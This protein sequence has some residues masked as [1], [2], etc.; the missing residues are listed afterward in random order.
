MKPASIAVIVAVSILL[1]AMSPIGLSSE[2][3]VR[4]ENELS[5][6]FSNADLT[7]HDPIEIVSNTDFETQ[8]W[9]GNGSANNPYRI[10]NLHIT[11]TTH[12]IKIENT[13]VEF[14]ITNCLL[15]GIGDSGVFLSNVSMGNI[16]NCIITEKGFAI[17]VHNSQNCTFA[18]IS[19]E[20]CGF[21]INIDTNS[22][23]CL[24]AHNTMSVDWNGVSVDDSHNISIMNNTISGGHQFG[25]LLDNSDDCHIWNN[26]ISDFQWAGARI[27]RTQN[28]LFE[29]NTVITTTVPYRHEYKYGIEAENNSGLTIHNNTLTGVADTSL[30]LSRY[31]G[32]RIENNTFDNGVCI[33]SSDI[34][35]LDHDVVNNVVQGKPLFY[36]EG[37][38]NSILNAS[39]YGQV[40]IVDAVNVTI[41]GGQF[42]DVSSPVTISRSDNCSIEY[43][44][45]SGCDVYSILIQFC[46][47]V[48]L[49]DL[50][51][52]DANG[53][54][55]FL[56]NSKHS[57]V[58]NCTILDI[59]SEGNVKSG[60]FLEEYC[61]HSLVSGNN[62]HRIESIGIR[63][64]SSEVTIQD[65]NVTESLYLFRGNC[66]VTN[67]NF[68]DGVLFWY[69]HDVSRLYHNF[70]SNFMG[71]KEI[72]YYRDANDT[73]ID[74]ANL[75]QL[76]LI[77]CS[78]MVVNNMITED[79]AQGMIIF[80]CSDVTVE[81]VNMSSMQYG[82]ETTFCDNVSFQEL[83]ISN[84]AIHGL[85]LDSSHN[86]TISNCEFIDNRVGIYADS[87]HNSTISHNL[88]LHNN[89]GIRLS[90][91]SNN[92]IF[93]ND[94][95]YSE[96]QNAVDDAG[97]NTWDN[98]IDTGNA[99]SDYSGTGTYLI[100]GSSGSVDRYPTL[101]ESPPMTTTTTPSPPTSPTSNGEPDNLDGMVYI[102]LAGVGAGILVI[103]VIFLK[104]RS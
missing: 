89:Y 84:S 2:T 77:E 72:G 88:F 95:G 47:N 15:E 101:L 54:G 71:T 17:A 58:I 83:S 11:A 64:Y 91:C 103:V 90:I 8:G 96:Y 36:N 56:D 51:I 92:T 16:E 45:T 23:N 59:H 10:E 73:E 46:T 66:N 13:S 9:P 31:S 57:K 94:I 26:T 69:G 25:I 79:V 37:M 28:C 104:R 27:M 33:T 4:I 68:Q 67:N 97:S 14:V 43:T 39:E 1:S 75:G 44:S 34:D 86:L 35:D 38:T 63:V 65:N 12:C 6:V 100:D 5:Q 78:N 99:W 49:T 40:I 82:I 53:H 32:A 50:L 62:I 48:T 80:N 42:V 85:D 70:S 81:H 76:V 74:G 22:V 18:Y 61:E 41:A 52:T 102:A 21:G 93:G 55:I 20:G 3:G 19:S 87:T 30:W 60:I 29:N 7:V 98:G 24:V